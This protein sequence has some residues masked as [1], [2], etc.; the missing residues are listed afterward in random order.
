MKLIELNKHDIIGLCKRFKVKK[1]YVF[2]TILTD[3]FNDKSDVD[4][5]FDFEEEVDYHSYSDLFLGFYNELKH[6]LG[7][8]VDLVDEKAIQNKYFKEELDETKY[9]I[10]G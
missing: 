5:S 1:L 4:F 10:Y 8:E 7:R 3:R 6:L 9:L 2:G